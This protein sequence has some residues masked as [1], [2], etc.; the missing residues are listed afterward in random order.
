MKIL[1]LNT[2]AS[3]GSYEYA[4]LARVSASQRELRR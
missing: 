2:Y 4:A 3:G 1:H